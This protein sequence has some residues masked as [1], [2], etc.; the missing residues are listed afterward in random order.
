MSSHRQW[1]G[2]GLARI[3]A[4][5]SIPL[6]TIVETMRGLNLFKES[7]LSHYL[8]M[9]LSN[10]LRKIMEPPAPPKPKRTYKKR[11]PKADG[12]T[13]AATR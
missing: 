2:R 7:S 8:F 11:R 5:D 13:T 12:Q 6:L 1:T 10:R 9:V 3:E 4:F